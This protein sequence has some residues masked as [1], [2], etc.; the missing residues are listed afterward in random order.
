[1]AGPRWR[2]VPDDPIRLPSSPSAHGAPV[3]LHHREGGS[4]PPAL[5]LHGG[6]GHDVYAFDRVIKALGPEHRVLVPDRTGYGRSTR[7]MDMPPR[8]HEAAAREM[9]AYLDRLGVEE[10]S[11]WGHSDGAVIALLMARDAPGRFPR[12]VAESTHLYKAKPSSRAFFES[13]AR[14]PDAFGSRLAAVLERDHGAGWR[15]V[16][17]MSGRAWLALAA[18]AASDTDDLYDGALGLVD[19][20]VLLLHGAN[21]P[22]TEP[23]ELDDLASSIPRARVERVP[24]AG[25][26]PHHEARAA[27]HAIRAGVRFLRGD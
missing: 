13:T 4:G 17:R 16:I 27:G 7:I 19:S 23:D 2:I 5:F 22:R 21:D 11:L 1:M 25:H 10:A 14:H 8:F 9:I 20:E 6:W 12:I 18:E 26:C 15:D 3:H 24:D